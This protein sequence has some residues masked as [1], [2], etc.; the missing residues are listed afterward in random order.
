[1]STRYHQ[2]CP[3]AM[4]SEILCNRWT[5]IVIRELMAGSRYFNDLH[6]GVPR[7]SPTLLSA[8]LKQLVDCGIARRIAQGRGRYAYELT[9]A[10][11]ELVPMIE[12]MGVW[13]H[14]WVGS[15]LRDEDL[16]AGLLMWD[17]RRGVDAAAFPAHRVTVKFEL[18]DAPRKLRHWWLVSEAGQVDLCLED[19]GHEVD[20]LVRATLRALTEVWMQHRR[21]ADA[22]RDGDLTLA[23]AEGLK[24]AL[25]GWLVG[26]PLARL[27][28]ASLVSRPLTPEPAD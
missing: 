10:G 3:V 22:L 18:H 2:F 6:R 27:G 20:L 12:M 14:R 9:A 4:A 7:M 8:R 5:L 19:P 16:D 13:G 25:P 24:R 26:S 28:A 15:R 17:I 23:G 21:F 1:M 11:T